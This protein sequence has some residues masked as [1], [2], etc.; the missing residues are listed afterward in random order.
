MDNKLYNVLRWS[1]Q[2]GLPGIAA[3]YFALAGIWELPYAEQVVG[4]LMA[5]TTFL[6]AI[7]GVNATLYSAK[8]LSLANA[9]TYDTNVLAPV[10]LFELPEQVYLG[11]KWVVLTIL[12]AFA[13]LYS[14]AAMQWNLP[15]SGQIAGT[16]ASIGTFMGLLL[17][18]SSIDIKDKI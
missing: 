17:R 18:I 15:Y 14:S 10:Y 2:L 8:K 3:L 5:V 6:G 13:T 1:C 12:P 16:I 7:L 11:L 4:T 9:G